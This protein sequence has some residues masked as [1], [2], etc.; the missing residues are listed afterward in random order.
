RSPVAKRAQIL[1]GIETEAAKGTP[2]SGLSAPDGRAVRLRAIF[3]QRYARGV[4]DGK[5]RGQNRHASV[6][7]GRYGRADRRGQDGRQ[8]GGG[9]VH[10]GEIDIDVQ[11]LSPNGADGG[12]A[13]ATGV[14]H[15]G[16]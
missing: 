14:G 8:M 4:G 11:R 3:H 5:Q 2:A 12:G 16:D 10:G 1:G 6:E 13:V 9:H 15:G 7:V